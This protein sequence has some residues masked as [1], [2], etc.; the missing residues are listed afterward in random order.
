MIGMRNQDGAVPIGSLEAGENAH[1]QYVTV[2]WEA[3]CRW[4]RVFQRLIQNGG[5]YD[6]GISAYTMIL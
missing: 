4:A 5:G 6:E 1:Q 3:L 2:T